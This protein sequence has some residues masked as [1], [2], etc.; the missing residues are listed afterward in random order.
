MG[1]RSVPIRFGLDRLKWV[2]CYNNNDPDQCQDLKHGFG[3]LS[4]KTRKALIL[5]PATDILLSAPCSIMQAA[6]EPRDVS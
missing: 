4:K 1:S 5:S 3:I 6:T 2:L